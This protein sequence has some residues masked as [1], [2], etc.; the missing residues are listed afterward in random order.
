MT[1]GNAEIILVSSAGYAIRFHEDEVRPMG[2]D[3]RGVKGINLTS[4]EDQVVGMDVVDPDA[5]LL[6]VTSKGV[7]KR[8]PLSEYPSYGRGARGVT[9][10]KLIEEKHGNLISIK[11]VLEGNDV[12]LVSEQG[13]LIR[14]AVADIRRISRSTQ[15]VQLMNLDENDKVSA[16]A[17]VVSR[18]EEE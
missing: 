18:D 16:V 9:T 6:V 14:M 10:I 1:S 2:R 8:T 11:T 3:T 12:I 13:V 5:D 15:G 7:G 4:A 17:Q